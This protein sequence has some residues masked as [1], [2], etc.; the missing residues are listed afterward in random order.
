MAATTV[1]AAGSGT[2]ALQRV[3]HHYVRKGRQ[4]LAQ[5]TP[6]DATVHEARKAIK[7]SRTALRLLRP[8]LNQGRYRR[9]DRT[10]RDTAH[11]LNA[12][13]DARVLIQA[14]A[15]LRREVPALRSNPAAAGLAA[16]LHQELSDARQRL[17]ARTLRD[18]CRTLRH[19]ERRAAQLS[20]GR[21]GW[22]VLGPA[23]QHLYRQGRRALPSASGHPADEALHEW[24]KRVQC[25]RYALKML[26]PLR[27]SSLGAWEKQATAIAEQLGAAHDL[28]LLH[29]RAQ[30]LE[31]RSGRGR[32]RLLQAIEGVRTQRACTA[33]V[34]GE[35]LYQP[36]PRDF[37]RQL[38]RAW[39]SWRRRQG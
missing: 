17:N 31:A 3:L 6:S 10:L 27:P 8:A 7:R 14:L 5:A 35:R 38:A 20:V 13:R 11:T 2:R 23:M 9:A 36:R 12:L 25:L 28:A 39:R 37:E 24:R 34:A 16:R 15:H 29:A 4:H 18:G 21:H 33:L 19:M 26:E 30:S 22:S 32:R 1:D